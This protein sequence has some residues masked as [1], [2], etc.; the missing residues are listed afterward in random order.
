MST[1]DR[2]LPFPSYLADLE[3]CQLEMDART[4]CIRIIGMQTQG[5][6]DTEYM[7]QNTALAVLLE[8][9]VSPL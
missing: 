9:I 8:N 3:A 1:R 6:V 4:L 5:K 7:Q 2:C